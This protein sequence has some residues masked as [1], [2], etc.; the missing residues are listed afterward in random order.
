MT[1][2]RKHA[3]LF[4]ATLLVARKLMPLLDR[5]EGRTAPDDLQLQHYEECAIYQASRILD[6]I[7]ARWPG[8]GKALTG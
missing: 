6:K 4:A 7:D 3:I 5:E 2:E 8:E 1:E